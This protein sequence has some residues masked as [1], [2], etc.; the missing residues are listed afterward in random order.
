MFFKQNILSATTD[1]L[2]NNVLIMDDK[3][4]AASDILLF[5]VVLSKYI[6]WLL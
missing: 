6:S 5:R 1:W 3:T 4:A 2:V